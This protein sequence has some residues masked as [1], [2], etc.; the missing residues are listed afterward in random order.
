MEE[1]TLNTIPTCNNLIRSCIANFKNLSG[2]MGSLRSPMI[3]KLGETRGVNDALEAE[4]VKNREESIR[5]ACENAVKGLSE[6]SAEMEK[7]ERISGQI[8]KLLKAFADFEEGMTRMVR[9]F[10]LLLDMFTVKIRGSAEELLE[11]ATIG[12]GLGDEGRVDK[13][14]G[15][16]ALANFLSKAYS[17]MSREHIEPLLNLARIS[18]CETHDDSE[19]HKLAAR[20]SFRA[21]EAVRKIRRKVEE[22]RLRYL[23][24]FSKGFNMQQQQNRVGS[25]RSA[26]IGHRQQSKSGGQNRGLETSVEDDD[27][28]TVCV[29]VGG[30]DT[31]EVTL[32]DLPEEDLE[33]DDLVEAV[34]TFSKEIVSGPRDD[35]DLGGKVFRIVPKNER[36]PEEVFVGGKRTK[37]AVIIKMK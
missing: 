12:A 28:G 4:E 18:S 8:S 32:L 2:S 7:G 25:R 35:P 11:E 22:D 34:E 3:K 13:L 27:T 20:M 24:R 33:D 19:R 21:E 1:A 23:F 36:V 9:F 6:V 31:I 29:M 26:A 14:A 5:S 37:A 15:E 16:L 17:E 30:E 10:N